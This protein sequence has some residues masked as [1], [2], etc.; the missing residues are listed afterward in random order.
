LVLPWASLPPE[1]VAQGDGNVEQPE[2]AE[3]VPTWTGE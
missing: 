3:E 2:E 1:E